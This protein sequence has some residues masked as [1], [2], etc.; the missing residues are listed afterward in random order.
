LVSFKRQRFIT[1]FL[2]PEPAGS[3][4]DIRV[5]SQRWQFGKLY[6]VKPG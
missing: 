5:K 6:V 3:Y 4:Q 2:S 1:D